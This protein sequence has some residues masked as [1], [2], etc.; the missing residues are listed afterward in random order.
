MRI[1]M[2]K[3]MH[4]IEIA[5]PLDCETRSLKFRCLK[6]GVDVEEG[7]RCHTDGGTLF[8]IREGIGAPTI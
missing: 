7:V 2:G 1:E 8:C 5:L 6:T 4:E 3:N